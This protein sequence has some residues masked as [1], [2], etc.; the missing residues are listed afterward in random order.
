MIFRFSFW[1]ITLVLLGVM[2]LAP[3][4]CAQ[5]PSRQPQA[6]PASPLPADLPIR[7]L[8]LKDG[9]YQA[10]DKL[11][12]RGDRVRYLSAERYEWEE[13]PASMVDWPA[14][15][16]YARE[17][18]KRELSPEAQAIDA[19]EQAERQKEEAR[20]P[21]V[22]PGLRLPDTGGIFLL[23]VYQREAQLN[24]LAQNDGEI[25]RNTG[26]NIL[27]ATVNPLASQKQTIELQGQHARIQAHVKNPFFYIKVEPENDANGRPRK[28]DVEC[29][30]HFRIVR[31]EAV[32]KKNVRVVGNVKVAIYGKV[33]QQEQFVPTR[34]ETVAGQAGANSWLK[35]T[36]QDPMDPGEYAVVEML[37][38]NEMNLYVWDF[39]VNPDAPPNAGAWFGGKP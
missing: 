38:D 22:A 4:T 28:D 13:V 5:T 8:I 2:A 14:T 32:P 31:A 10:V 35:L 12:V 7:R 16:K 20:T 18:G 37:K 1:P 23:D 11:E 30:N 9:S 39:G 36:P 29:Q 34:C 24:E 19:E 27:R 6:P 33:S 26:G 25:K 17:G 3:L 21:L 15:E